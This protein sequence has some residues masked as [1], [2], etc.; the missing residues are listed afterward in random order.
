M[1]LSP[2]VWQCLDSS[3]YG[4]GGRL[5]RFEGGGSMACFQFIDLESMD[6]FSL[7]VLLYC[8]VLSLLLF[9]E[10]FVI[11]W[12]YKEFKRLFI[13]SFGDLIVWKRIMKLLLLQKFD[14]N[15]RVGHVMNEWEDLFVIEWDKEIH[16][17]QLS[18]EMPMCHPVL[19]TNTA[20]LDPDILSLAMPAQ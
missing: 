18:Y 13:S 2:L 16:L 11:G 10:D 19:P 1:S 20:T 5:M 12:R 3:A 6:I 7:A 15:T 17:S 8:P 14:W 9:S 4:A